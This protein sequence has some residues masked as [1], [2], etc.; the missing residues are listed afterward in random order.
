MKAKSRLMKNL[1]RDKYLLILVAPVL[2]YYI[3]FHYMPMY[4]T[5]MAFV[6]YVPGQPILQSEW[7]GFKWFHEFFSSIFFWRLIRNTFLLSGLTMIFTFPLPII[8]AIVLN[9]V[10][11]RYFKKTIQTISYMPHFVSLV[12]IVGIVVNML[13]VRDGV[14]NNI[15]EQFGMERIDF[16]NDPNGFRPLYIIIVIWQSYGWNSIIYMASLSSID[17]SLYEA[18]TI[19]GANRWQQIIYITL[20]SLRPVVMMLL[21][22]TVGMLMSVG[23]EQ[24]MLMYNPATYGTADVI[25]TYVYRR[26]IIG[27]QFS[28]GAAVGL[29][30]SLIN[31]TLLLAANYASK[32]L[33]ASSLW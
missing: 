5:L 8:F 22:L 4:G 26:G 2:I 16:M 9:E 31:F 10:K 32:K 12:V 17:P 25:S 15:L 23:F 30:N 29:F 11:N 6:D 14:I 24:V 7:V 13:S 28:F 1:S 18:A 27:S 20:P 33:T 21:I 3:V 19:D